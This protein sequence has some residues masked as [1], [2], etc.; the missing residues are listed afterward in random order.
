MSSLP[1]KHV[2]I[3]PTITTELT[4]CPDPPGGHQLSLKVQGEAEEFPS[5]QI[6]LAPQGLSTTTTR[7]CVS[8]QFA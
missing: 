8:A 2:N 7:L 5:I 4:C 3:P 6:E 1:H